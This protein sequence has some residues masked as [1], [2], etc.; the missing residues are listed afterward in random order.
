MLRY[1]IYF[2]VYHNRNSRYE[3]IQ[4]VHNRS[5]FDMSSHF[6]SQMKRYFTMA[7]RD[8][9]F[10]AAGPMILQERT[11][12]GTAASRQSCARHRCL[13]FIALT[14]ILSVS[15]IILGAVILSVL[16]GTYSLHRIYVLYFKSLYEYI[17]CTQTHVI[18]IIIIK[19]N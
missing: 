3:K 12:T 6:L 18:L 16:R 5:G 15:I 4:N 9:D 11:S 13:C 14:I 10:E 8:I 7:D 2:I 1:Y 19:Y 17:T